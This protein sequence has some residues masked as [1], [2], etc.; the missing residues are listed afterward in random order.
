[1]SVAVFDLTT[2]FTIFRT[3]VIAQNGEQPGRHI[4]AGLEGIDIGECTQQGLLYQIVRTINISAKGNS[5]CAETWHRSENGFADRLVHGHYCGS[6]FPLPSRRLIKSLNRSGTPWFTTSSYMARNC[7]PRRACT[8]RPSLAG[9]AL[10]FLLRAGVVSIGC[11]G[12]TG[13]RSFI[14]QPQPSE[15]QAAAGC[16]LGPEQTSELAD[17]PPGTELFCGRRVEALQVDWKVGA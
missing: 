17:G 6:F 13:V 8:S 9:F 11:C 16:S 1:M 12:R 4:G 7:W 15:A 3:E 5:E 2:P 10:T 14:V